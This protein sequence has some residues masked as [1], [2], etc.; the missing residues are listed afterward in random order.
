M[1]PKFIEVHAAGDGI[2][3]MVNVENV[4][5]FGGDGKGGGCFRMADNSMWQT[6]ESYDELKDLITDCGCLIHKADPRLNMDH[7]LTMEDLKSMVG[8]PVWN[9]NSGKWGLVKE[10]REDDVTLVY[11]AADWVMVD[12]WWVNKF[13]LYRMRRYGRPGASGS[14]D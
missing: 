10:V 11:E 5:G 9:S 4:I 14:G 3:V 2:A 12:R 7:P 6:K 1:Y 8:E 13:P